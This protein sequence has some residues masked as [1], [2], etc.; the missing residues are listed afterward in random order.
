MESENLE[1]GPAEWKQRAIIGA[2]AGIR[3]YTE[4][5]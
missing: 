2:F 1:H 4:T 3:K 5:L